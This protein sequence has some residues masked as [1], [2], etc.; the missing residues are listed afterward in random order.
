MKYDLKYVDVIY[1]VI[2]LT[3]RMQPP[4]NWQKEPELRENCISPRKQLRDREKTSNL[5]KNC[6]A[7]DDNF[8]LRTKLLPRFHLPFFSKVSGVSVGVD[9][10]GY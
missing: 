1:V 5:R 7:Q 6:A 8:C 4:Q 3:F 9:G 2:G 10:A